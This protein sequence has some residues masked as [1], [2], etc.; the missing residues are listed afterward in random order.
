LHPAGAEI[1]GTMFKSFLFTQQLQHVD[2][3][4]STQVVGTDI[5]SALGMLANL[6][7]WQC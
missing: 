6:N 7:F 2:S 3:A 5:E 4:V 1:L